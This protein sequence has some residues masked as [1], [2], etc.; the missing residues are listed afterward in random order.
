MSPSE[1]YPRKVA[2]G[3]REIGPGRFEVRVFVGRDPRSG[4]VRHAQRTLCAGGLRAAKKAQTDLAV[5]VAGGG[6][7]KS[8]ETFGDLLEE[9]LDFGRRRGWSSKT[10]SENRRKVD[11]VIKPILGRVRL[12][13][14]DAKRLDDFYTDLSRGL[15]RDGLSG[16]PLSARTVLA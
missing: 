15:K 13:K 7:A 16:E 4:S 2:D 1:N 9:W 12:D 8:G 10:S 11:R 5:E 3:I 6:I 14:L